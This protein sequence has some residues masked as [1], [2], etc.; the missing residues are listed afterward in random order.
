MRSDTLRGHLDSLV[1]ATLEGESLHGYAIMGVLR[2][3]SGG[4][5]DVPAGTIYPALR[6]LEAAGHVESGWDGFGGR[7]RRV[8][9]L[10]RS[11]RRH[12]AQQREEWRT[13]TKVVEGVLRPSPQGS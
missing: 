9:K 2:V 7:R 13:F 12:L 10:T 6:R 1:L 11:G 3:R 8:Y 5:L 4:E